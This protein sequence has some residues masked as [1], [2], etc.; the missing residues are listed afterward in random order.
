LDYLL[1]IVIL[2]AIY[3][4]L[5]SSLN[6]VVG[7]GGLLSLCHAGFYAIG[8]YASAL[9]ALRWGFSFPVTAMVAAVSAALCAGLIAIPLLKLRGDYFILGSLGFQ[10][11][12][13]DLI[14]NGDPVTNGAMGLSRI[15]RPRV[16]GFEIGTHLEYAALYMVIATGSIL[17]LHYVT[18]SP[19]GRALNAVREDETAVTALGR[20]VRWIRIRAFA[21]AAAG[22]G[23]AGA[24]YAHYVTYLDA[25]SFTFAESVYILSLVI[26]GGVAT[27]R[28]P[29]L[30]ALLLV[31]LPE[32]LR[33][34]GF[35]SDLDSN[36]RQLVYGMLLILF[37]SLR[38]RG[39][40]G[41]DV[42]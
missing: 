9:T 7:H 15:P 38:P 33:F 23:V 39:L 32:A 41:R 10:I 31:L 13:V 21:I 4:L 16:F 19:F 14:Q 11:I 35:S 30:G 27:T 18:T 6:V 42:F 5:A 25:T 17:L 37:A 28:G 3:A 24:M 22:A 2:L 29:I 8:A 40:A 26:V 34:V 12:I 20:D 36:I 1:T